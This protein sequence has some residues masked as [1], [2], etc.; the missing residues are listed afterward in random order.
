MN[1]LQVMARYL[2]LLKLLSNNMIE[3]LILRNELLTL[4]KNNLGK[5]ILPNGAKIEAICVLPDPSRGWNYPE[6]GTKTIGLECI[7]KQPAPSPTPNLGGEITKEYCWEILLKQWDSNQNL[8]NLSETLLRF[9]SEKYQLK[10]FTYIPPSNKLLTIEQCKIT[11]EEY[12]IVSL[13]D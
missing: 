8:L 5:Y 1:L 12:Q 4:L 13:S 3:P 2:F 6:E 10:E 11:L 9:A 7:I